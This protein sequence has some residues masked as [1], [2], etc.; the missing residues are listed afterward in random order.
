[1]ADT[2]A[3][4]PRRFLGFKLP[5][6]EDA[7]DFV[8]N[9]INFLKNQA[10][11]T[12][13]RLLT[14]AGILGAAWFMN[15]GVGAASGFAPV[16]IGGVL[17][18]ASAGL[19]AFK[20]YRNERFYE[21]RM[22]NVF[23]DEV[24]TLLGKDPAII[25]V[26]DL[27]VVA[28]GNYNKG[29]KP[30]PVIKQ[31]LEK[32]GQKHLLHFVTTAFAAVT[33]FSLISLTG[34]GIPE[35]V[36][37]VKSTLLGSEATLGAASSAFS[38][39]LQEW[40][41][42]STIG[43]AIG[44]VV[45]AVNQVL[46]YAGERVFGIQHKSAYEL[47][48]EISTEVN[49]GRSVSKEKVFEV[50]VA[51]DPSLA[52]A[53][54]E[55]FGVSYH[56]MTIEEQ[57]QAMLDY[58]DPREIATATQEVN[59]RHIQPEELAFVAVGQHSGIPRVDNPGEPNRQEP[60]GVQQVFDKVKEEFGIGDKSGGIEKETQD[61]IRNAYRSDVANDNIPGFAERF[62][63]REQDTRSHVEKLGKATPLATLLERELAK[64]QASKG[65]EPQR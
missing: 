4:A 32:N 65:D 53:I 27:E 1:M 6:W 22:I 37:Q 11:Y 43:L 55:R 20:H 19:S 24:G 52:Y 8:P 44:T 60:K 35:M 50:F 9:A 17:I 46:D 47:I 7:V 39:F 58:G 36:D 54:E 38:G 56:D 30:N 63:P 13:G 15:I 57:H 12:G 29:I 64:A 2:Q 5:T 21:Q 48:S 18:A 41:A 16:I 23:R 28:Q 51:A 14:Y 49:R 45:S 59:G 3:H 33:V 42:I 40:A 26:K 62:A 34:I 31:A 25:T 61:S 10:I